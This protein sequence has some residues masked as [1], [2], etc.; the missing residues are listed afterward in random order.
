M[1]I[2]K[3]SE[4]FPPLPHPDEMKKW[5][6]MAMQAGC[7]EEVLMENSGRCAFNTLEY[8][9]RS[10]RHKRI[11]LLMGGGNN[12]GDAAC[13]ARYVQDAGAEVLVLHTRGLEKY[14]GAA[15]YHIRL[16]LDSGV[17]FIFLESGLKTVASRLP[18][19][20]ILVDG[21]LGTGFKGTLRQET[22]LLIDQFNNFAECCKPFVLALDIPSGLDGR[23]GQPSPL[24]VR[25]NATITFA[26]AKSGLLMPGAKNWTGQVHVGNIGL[27]I[28]QKTACSSSVF[29]I[30]SHCLGLLPRLPSNAYKNVFGHV[31]IIGGAGRFAGAAHLAARAALRTGAGLV[32]SIS[33][34]A[35]AAEIRNALPEIMTIGLGD[36]ASRQWPDYPPDD[37]EILIKN[38]TALVI[39]P[40]FGRDARALRFLELVMGQDQR[41]PTVLD[42]DAL[43]LMA[44]HRTL[45]D[46]VRDTDILTPHPGEA[47]S[48]LGLDSAAVQRDRLSALAELKALTRGTVVLKGAGTMISNGRH[49]L[50]CPYDVPQLSAGGTGDVLAGL[51]GS[52]LGQKEFDHMDGFW[53]AGIGVGIHALA[54]IELGEEYGLRGNLASEVADRIP[55]VL[56]KY[57]LH[58]P[59]HASENIL[60]CPQF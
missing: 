51:I 14:A 22:A 37:W 59:T 43:M 57:T 31:L 12:G 5:D 10:V 17:K 27:P 21:L 47:A 2:G 40:G 45:F 54:G 58:S 48:L 26:A 60:P 32:S 42:A 50:L 3:S 39:G 24:A 38:S 4:F 41:P 19:P 1:Q 16:A 56:N 36:P 9:F 20:D 52:L 23:T 13:L 29:L 33:P 30:D 46:S 15:K 35:C 49:I 25:A 11:M 6:Q 55:F 34:A 8:Y 7:L 53:L 28:R 44:G 18:P